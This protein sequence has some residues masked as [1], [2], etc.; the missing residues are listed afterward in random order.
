MKPWFRRL[1]TA[2]QKSVPL[3][4][5]EFP[6]RHT[7][8]ADRNNAFA[9]GLYAHLRRRTGN[10]IFSPFSIRTALAITY[11]GARG[12]TA[13][14]I[15]AAL[16]FPAAHDELDAALKEM[17]GRLRRSVRDEYEM[18]TANS[19]WVQ[20]GIPLAP[21]FLAL[22][23]SSDDDCIKD[24][25]F[26]HAA[27]AARAR[28]NAWVEERTN[29]RI[30]DLIPAGALSP[31]EILVIVNAVY[32]KAKWLHA[33]DAALT[34]DEPFYLDDGSEVHAR[35][36]RYQ[37]H[38]SYVQTNDFQAVDLIY[39]HGDAS[40]LV[41]LPMRRNGLQHLEETLSIEMLNDTLSRMRGRTVDL[42][43]P[44]FTMTSS[45]VPVHTFL[46]M[47]GVRRLFDSARADLSGINGKVPPDPEA[48]VVSHVLHN[49]F[50]DVNERGTE[51]AAAT[52]VQFLLGASP[53]YREAPVVF[54]ADHPFV[55][56]IRDRRS[57][58]IL[59]L[60]RMMHPA[61]W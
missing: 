28:I 56:A 22:L 14:E 41:L 2:E 59:F 30:R 55:F 8:D 15:R 20:R 3:A 48:L 24:V 12:E 38:F 49:A 43:L 25:D 5:R 57:G 51:A 36:M 19:L 53:A 52:A 23:A 32:F 17:V 7:P 45:T 6:A 34:H 47:L 44:R 1:F 37:E 42:T 46:E 21:A 29:R 58:A 4:Q 10:L 18:A 13:E 50:V 54:R 40:M 9:F 31:G 11:A 33:F 26:R 16:H 27:E 35:L 61:R 39:R 60:G